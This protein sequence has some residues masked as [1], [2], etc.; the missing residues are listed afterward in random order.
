MQKDY[1]LFHLN[2]AKEALDE[3]I[4]D[5]K[6]NSEYDTPEFEVDIQHLYHHI[7]TA[8]NSKFASN[9]EI[10]ECSGED[11]NKWRDF[12]TDIEMSV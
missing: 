4:N 9:K 11:F 7:N 6:S 3:I 1:I 12:P 8:W 2:E 5:L 10:E